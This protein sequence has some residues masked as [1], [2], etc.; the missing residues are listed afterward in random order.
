MKMHIVE[1][2]PINFFHSNHPT[3]SQ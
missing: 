3:S 1:E 2:M